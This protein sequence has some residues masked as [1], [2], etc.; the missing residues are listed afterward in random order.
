MSSQILIIGGGLVGTF[1]ALHCAHHGI[2]STVI[3]QGDPQAFL[4]PS[5]DGRTTA[6]AFGTKL[7]FEEIGAWTEIAPY[8]APIYDVKV[9]EQ[10]SAWIVHYDHQEIGSEPL[11]YIVENQFLRAALYKKA[12]ESEKIELL[13][14]A[15]VQTIQRHHKGVT[16]TLEEGSCHEGTLLVGADGRFSEVRDQANLKTRSWSYEQMGLV[17][18]VYHDKP[19]KNCAW[20]VFTPKGPFAILP[21]IPCPIFGRHRSGIVWTIP[22]EEKERLESLSN[23]NLSKELSTL[24][25]FYGPLEVAGQRWMFPLSAAFVRKFI[26]DR[27]VLIG[28]AAHVVHPIAGQG[29]NLGW[30]DAAVLAQCLKKSIDI[31]ID[32]GSQTFL[33]DYQ[34]QR[35]PDHL[36]ILGVTDGVNRLFSNKSTVLGFLR[37]GGLAAVNHL[38]PLRKFFMRRAMGIS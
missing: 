28:D 31:G 18:H 24:F 22:Q 5:H 38:P 17:C 14:P 35:L 1:A 33:E 8:A 9:F 16:V 25:D 27:T 3:D 13:A 6:V 37:K 10:N 34:K 4:H 19:H 30:R 21:M 2:S 26:A 23:E 15:K 20:E 29:V 32:I 12:L 7:L 11:G 36:S